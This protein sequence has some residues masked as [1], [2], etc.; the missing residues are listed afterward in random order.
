MKPALLIIDPVTAFCGRRTDNNN[1]T[2]IRI[3]MARL[4]ELA[5]LGAT[6]TEKR[7]EVSANHEKLNKYK[8]QSEK[9]L[10]LQT[11]TINRYERELKE[12]RV[13]RK[14]W[15]QLQK[16][17]EESE[18]KQR[19]KITQQRI[20]AQAD[21]HREDIREQ[22]KTIKRRLKKT[23]KCPYCD[24]A[25]GEDPHADLFTQSIEA[26]CRHQTTWL[27]FVVVAISLKER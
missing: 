16:Q 6:K 10:L 22:T 8:K 2:D 5:R 15:R 17:M 20:K 19:K 18:R 14:A 4:Q 9:A 24:G 11:W 25:L 7:S 13:P 26:V 3:I 23:E 12:K 1:A 21:A 27:M